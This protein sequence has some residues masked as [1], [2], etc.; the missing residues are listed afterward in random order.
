MYGN[1]N[2]NTSKKVDYLYLFSKLKVIN[3]KYIIAL[4]PIVR[5]E[6]RI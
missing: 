3:L 5:D 2:K 1:I 6:E 4:R